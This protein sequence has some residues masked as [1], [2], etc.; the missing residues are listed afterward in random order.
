MLVS[1]CFKP[2]VEVSSRRSVEQTPSKA[3]SEAMGRPRL[4]SRSL[5]CYEHSACDLLIFKSPQL[6]FRPR[7]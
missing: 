6:L 4:L 1:T 5:D 3:F 7:K 2:F